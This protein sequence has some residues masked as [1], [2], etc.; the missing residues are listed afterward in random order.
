MIQIVRERLTPKE[1]E[2]FLGQPFDSMIKFVADVR[3]GILAFGGELHADAQ[4]L[5]L[6]N[7]SRQSDL[8]GANFHPKNTG[9]ER[10]EFRSMINI[11]PSA[12]NPS[13][14]LRDPKIRMQV[15]EIVERLLP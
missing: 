11:R 9:P 10:V 1:V 13:N 7:G 8:W 14:E 15:M 5:L 2:K 12:G 3:Q 6:E 4:A